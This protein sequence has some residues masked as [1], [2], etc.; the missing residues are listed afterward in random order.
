M[1]KKV[2]R[3]KLL[4]HR[5]KKEKNLKQIK[6]VAKEIEVP[7]KVEKQ[8]VSG[9]LG[10]GNKKARKRAKQLRHKLKQEAKIQKKI[11]DTPSLD[12]E[13]KSTEKEKAVQ[14]RAASGN[15]KNRKRAKQLR[16]KLKQEARKQK[17]ATPSAKTSSSSSNLVQNFTSGLK[18]TKAPLPKVKAT[19]TV[20]TSTSRE[21]TRESDFEDYVSK[22]PLDFYREQLRA[23][24][25]EYSTEVDKYIKREVSRRIVEKKAEVID[26]YQTKPLVWVDYVKE[27]QRLGLDVEPGDVRVVPDLGRMRLFVEDWKD[28]YRLIREANNKG[29]G[30]IMDQKFSEEDAM[31]EATRWFIK[32][33]DDLVNFRRFAEHLNGVMYNAIIEYRR[34]VEAIV[35]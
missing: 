22:L 10:A 26:N 2:N 28:E 8:Q 14:N 11:S 12:L 21:T 24:E 33:Q 20:K 15:A 9:N 5:L 18:T 31:A 29:Y 34:E 4:K 13:N 3:K 19:S 1:G 32:Y 25:E 7:K 27:L 23:A 30:E 6:E 16:H 35:F 17:F